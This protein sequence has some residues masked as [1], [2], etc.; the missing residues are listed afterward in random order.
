[1]TEPTTP[2]PRKPR[3]P[4]RNFAKMVSDVRAYRDAAIEVLSEQLGPEGPGN[5]VNSRNAEISASIRAYRA[6]LA[7]LGPQ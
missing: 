5:N 2:K 4:K 1:M 3:A 7:R 6:V